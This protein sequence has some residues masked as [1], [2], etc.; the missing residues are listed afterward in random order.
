MQ[1]ILVLKNQGIFGNNRS[2]GSKDSS[3]LFADVSLELS[4]GSFDFSLI[5]PTS[6]FRVYFA[7]GAKVFLY[8]LAS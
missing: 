5:H 7:D 1:S 8:F 2:G 6:I 4:V 3:G